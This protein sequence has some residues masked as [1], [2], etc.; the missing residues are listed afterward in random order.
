MNTIP[1]IDDMSVDRLTS[2]KFKPIAS[3]LDVSLA[4]LASILGISKY[5][6]Y[7][8]NAQLSPDLSAH[9]VALNEVLNLANDYFGSHS[10]SLSW[11][12]TFNR[13]LTSKPI[14]LCNSMYGI[15]RIEN[16]ILKLMHG[17]TA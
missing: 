2:S 9:L 6:V 8:K 5:S 14:D 16:S 12:N 17:M 1:P 3:E 13:G 11:M 10:S 4:A 15:S 7:R